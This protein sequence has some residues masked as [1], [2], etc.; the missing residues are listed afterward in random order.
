MK[1]SPDCGARVAGTAA[2]PVCL[3]ACAGT[4]TDAPLAAAELP[5]SRAA[6]EPNP[7]R[8]RSINT[9]FLNASSCCRLE[10][11]C[12]RAAVAG[13]LAGAVAT[14]AVDAAPGVDAADPLA[15]APDASD[16]AG[17]VGAC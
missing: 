2:G 16:T 9:R 3:G 17:T 4:T 10:N 7:W 5:D 6:F 8:C 12:G 14:A 11:G 15:P 13:A 1:R